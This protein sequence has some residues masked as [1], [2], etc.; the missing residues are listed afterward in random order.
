MCVF[1]KPCVRCRLGLATDCEHTCD[2]LLAFIFNKLPSKNKL[3]S[4]FSKLDDFVIVYLNMRYDQ[5]P[6]HF[7]G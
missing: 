7:R 5:P 6:Y 3:N 4:L 2:G 1:T